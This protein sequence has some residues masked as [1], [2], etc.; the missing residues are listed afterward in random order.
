MM[1][2]PS[3]MNR[4]TQDIFEERLQSFEDVRQ[5]VLNGS[6][7]PRFRFNLIAPARSLWASLH[8][9]FGPTQPA[10]AGLTATQEMARAHNGWSR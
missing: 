2:D 5:A 6:A 9:H 7:E 3:T 4:L 10:T 1:L 8:R